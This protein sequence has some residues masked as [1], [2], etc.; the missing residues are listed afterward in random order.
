[1]FFTKVPIFT[2]KLIQRLTCHLTAVDDTCY[3]VNDVD[4][5]VSPANNI[6]GLRLTRARFQKKICRCLGTCVVTN[7]SNFHENRGKGTEQVVCQLLQLK[8][9]SNVIFFK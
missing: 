9:A 5:G 6:S 7:R 1:M 2:L 3:I 4:S 8:L